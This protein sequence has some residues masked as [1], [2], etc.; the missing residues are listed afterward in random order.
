MTASWPQDEASRHLLLTPA[1]MGEAERATIAAGMPGIRLMEN[2]GYAVAD[3]IVV[4]HRHGTRVVVVCGPGNNGGDGFVAAKVLAMR[5]LVV[6]L[7]LLGDPDKLTGDA[8]LAARSWRGAVEAPGEAAFRDADVVVDALFGAGLSRDLDGEAARL[9]GW[10]NAAGAR[11]A[12]VIAVDLP[13]GVDGRTGRVLGCAVKATRSVTFFRRKPGHLLLPGRTLCGRVVVA[14]IGIA[15]GVL[16][17]IAPAVAANHPD[18]WREKWPVRRPDDHKYAR[19]AALVACGGIEATGAA[20]LAAAACLRTGAGVVTL[21]APSEAL[22]LAGAQFAALI[23]RRADDAE[24]FARLAA[25]PRLRAIV[26]GPAW[27]SARGHGRGL[28]PRWPPR[29]VSSSTPTP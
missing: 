15:P 8:A 5:G 20:R 12:S 23:V 6:R 7:L 2:A 19:G 1:E 16:T 28:R 17:K 21:A 18:L 14:D 27:V 3:D 11:G 9:V 26:V 22:A 24:A 4:R 29:P 10:I 25:E 13:S